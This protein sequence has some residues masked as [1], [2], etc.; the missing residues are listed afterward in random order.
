MIKLPEIFKI[1]I[2]RLGANRKRLLLTFLVLTFLCHNTRPIL[3]KNH[4]INHPVDTLETYVK[5]QLK[6]AKTAKNKDW[7]KAIAIMDHLL[8]DS[9]VASNDSLY[10]FVKY[11]YSLYLLMID[12]NIQSREMIY[13]IIDYYEK[14]NPKRWT[15]LKT[16]LG[17]LDIRM[18]AY[19][20]AQ[21]HLQ[22]ALPFAKNLK[23]PITEGLINLYLSNI[24]R[25][26]SDFGEAFRKADEALKIFKKI[27]RPDW[28]LE[29]KT[30]L[31]YISILAKDYEGATKYIE[32]IFNRES[33][34]EDENFLVSPTLYAGIMNYEL[35]NIPL[36][37]EQLEEGL[38]RI[39]SLGNFPDLTMVY[40][41]MSQISIEENDFGKAEDYIQKALS[42]T[43]ESHN[44]RHKLS[45]ELILIK[46]ESVIRPEKN[47]LNNLRNVYQWA[48][49]NDDNILLKES[50]NL[51]SEYYVDRGHYKKALS[52]NRIYIN[53]SEE[54][55]QK[56]RLSEITLIKE[57]SKYAQEVQAR[58][59]KAQ[60]LQAELTLSEDRRRMMLL[61]ILFLV[62]MSGFLMYFYS[63]KKQAYSS[64]EI[65]NQ[66]LKKAEQVLEEKNSELEKY[67]AYNL[68]LENFAY[69]ASHDLKSPLQTISNF[70][71]L[72]KKKTKDRLH[73]NE[74][75]YL[76]FITKGTEDMMT[77]VKD[78]LDYSILQKSK[79]IKEKIDVAEFLAY[80]LQL[81]Q[82]LIKE[83]NAT[84]SL[85]LR[86]RYIA[87]DRSKL[88]QLLQNLISNSVKFHK[89]EEPPKVL[90]SA[91]SDQNDWFF[92]IEDNGI[93]IAP[94]YF[95]KIFL[96]FKRLH[97]KEEY[98]GTGIGLSM[99]KKIVEMHGG[100]IWVNSIVGEGSTFTFSLPK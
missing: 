4:Q 39:N 20:S 31:A 57:K 46:L 2:Y 33:T 38:N 40:R 21:K 76:S 41:Y 68:Q 92:K 78:I 54:K 69:I 75:Q 85:D 6:K 43:N 79:L 89:K 7:S 80:I 49:T 24:C 70:S 83:N 48:L 22:G 13:E 34:I 63:Q 14:N 96:I 8:S 64:L 25:F 32:E 16:R 94:D 86:A 65:S 19:D 81:N 26:K 3:A 45:A 50:S 62:L 44:E 84:V 93:G 5:E 58:E 35:G 67:I 27:E 55:F 56:D 100:K 59:I 90:I 60:K 61:G 71:H 1:I 23:M 30:T 91:Y 98:E 42:I 36:A 18:G 11:R 77:L 72:L 99:C 52:F 66:E 37:K 88:L 15:N 12:E 10:N 82:S 53:A 97:R 17:T 28:I 73:A 95:N 29:A 74:L 51:I 9:L 47:N 87:G